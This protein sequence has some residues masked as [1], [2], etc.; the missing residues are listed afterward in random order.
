MKKKDNPSTPPKA[1]RTRTRTTSQPKKPATASKGEGKDDKETR[2]RKPTV[3]KKHAPKV[4]GSKD[5]DKLPKAKP[6]RKVPSGAA[7]KKQKKQA[8]R[9]FESATRNGKPTPVSAAGE[10]KLIEG[11]P[12]MRTDKKKVAMILQYVTAGNPYAHV[13]WLV[14]IDEST[15]YRWMKE[16]KSSPIGTISKNFYDKVKKANGE[17]AHRNVMRI[18]K[19]VGGWQASAWF[20]ERRFPQDYGRTDRVQLGS[21][22]DK[23][24]LIEERGVSGKAALVALK[25]IIARKPELLDDLPDDQS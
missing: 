20:L 15:F 2:G 7:R 11:R 19:A 22:P 6:K 5:P 1:V 3:F 4:R 16:G 21:E 23:P 24:V 25:A 14:G 18:Q 10:P 8:P 9:T 13:C 12:D 17:A